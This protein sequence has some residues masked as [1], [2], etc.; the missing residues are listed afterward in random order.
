MGLTWA[1]VWAPVG[2]LIG[3][4]VDPDDSMD[5]MWVLIGAYPGFLCGVVFSA[6][7][8]FAERRRR[9]EDLSFFRFGA[10]G[11][12]GG[13]VVGMLPFAVGTANPS[14][15]LWQWG[16]I[17]IGS[18]TLLSAGSAVGSLW[19]ARAAKKRADRP[20]SSRV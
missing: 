10:W 11:A 6:V 15:P 5:E 18:F 12:A 1:V 13:L 3:M 14:L 8:G 9:L 19:L 4:I 16:V 17:V 2:V 7:L 20:A